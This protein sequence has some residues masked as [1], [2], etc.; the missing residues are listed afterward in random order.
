M[1]EAEVKG[2]HDAPEGQIQSGRETQDGGDS[3][4]TTVLIGAPPTDLGG[5]DKSRGS[6]CLARQRRWIGGLG[7][8]V[9]TVVDHR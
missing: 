1:K 2:V 5:Y 9:R 8:G 7:G 3:Q 4:R 6:R